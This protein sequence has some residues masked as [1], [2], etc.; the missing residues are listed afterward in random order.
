MEIRNQEI[1]DELDELIVDGGQGIN[2]SLL[3][4]LLK[5]NLTLSKDGNI[6]YEGL[7][8]KLSERKRMLLY[9]LA[10]KV[11]VD[12]KLKEIREKA[13]Y[14]EIAEGAFISLKNIARIHLRD[15]RS[16]VSKDNEGYFILNYN[17]IKCKEIL[18]KNGS[19]N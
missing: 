1:K 4:E 8:Y 9:L 7:F 11:I 19:R 2:T 13:D 10:R 14:K 3:A 5:G 18:I 16:V 6:N 15:L 12:K 17:L